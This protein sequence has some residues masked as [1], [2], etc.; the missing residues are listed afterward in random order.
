MTI[1]IALT[2][3]VLINDAAR[4]LKQKNVLWMNNMLIGVDSYD[5]LIFTYLNSPNLSYNLDKP[6]VFNQRQ[7]SKF[8]KSVTTESYFDINTEGVHVVTTVHTI[9][10]EMDIVY[11]LPTIV[12]VKHRI[13]NLQDLN[14]KIESK[15]LQPEK[16]ITEDIRP[17][18]S[19]SKSSGIFNYIYDD[20][21]LMTLFSGILPLTK[22][23]KTFVIVADVG[24]DSFISRF[25]V[26]KKQY[27]IFIYL[28]FRKA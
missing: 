13:D 23:D 18:Y 12:E 14:A 8:M 9:S 25:R 24:S 4:A 7:L 5:Y 6:L 10:E 26:N 21:H 11:D 17:V 27:D 1:R 16:N 3:L 28:M 2:D 20:N 15:A 19:L 22:N